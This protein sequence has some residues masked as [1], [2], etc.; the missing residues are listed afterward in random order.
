ME[1]LYLKKVLADVM[2]SFN[3]VYILLCRG[4]NSRTANEFP[5]SQSE[6]DVFA[7]AVRCSEHTVLNLFG[8]KL[9]NMCIAF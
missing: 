9:L 1:F 5:I 8:K 4:F 7:L 2:L 3:D 6:Y